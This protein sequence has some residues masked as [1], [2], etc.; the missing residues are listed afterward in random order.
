MVGPKS[1]NP[2][3]TYLFRRDLHHESLCR[4]NDRSRVMTA[5]K[6][7]RVAPG[8]VP[9]SAKP[10]DWSLLDQ[11][12]V[13]SSQSTVVGQKRKSEPSSSAPSTQVAASQ[14]IDLDDS[15]DEFG[16]APVEEVAKDEHY[17][18]LNSQVVGV[19]YYKGAEAVP[20]PHISWAYTV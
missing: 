20:S 12:P 8:D 7:G 3:A 5:I 2:S 9:A 1:G 17:I 4:S 19:Q 10:L 18:D 6:A 15:E 14:I 13:T 11:T 16:V